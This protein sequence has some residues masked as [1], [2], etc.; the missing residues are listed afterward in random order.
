EGGERGRGGV[1]EAGHV[2]AAAVESRGVVS[3]T[4]VRRAE[5]AHG[6]GGA[7]QRLPGEIELAA[8]MGG[9]EGV[10][11]RGGAD[12]TL[13][14]ILQGEQVPGR[15]RHL[16]AVEL[17]ELAVKPVADERLAGSALRLSDLVLMVREDEVD[18]SAMDVEGR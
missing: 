15:L 1:V 7:L 8:V 17:Q 11:D 9:E 3:Q 18:A 6:L 4:V 13:Q 12:A 14:E 10:A 2:G 16:L 5:A